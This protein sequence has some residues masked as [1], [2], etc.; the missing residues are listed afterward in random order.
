MSIGN[1]FRKMFFALLATTII[2]SGCKKEDENEWLSKDVLERVPEEILNKAKDLG[3]E[4]NGGKKPPNIEGSY[5]A[6]PVILVN[7]TNED[8]YIGGVFN[9]GTFIFSEQNYKELTVLSYIEEM[10]VGSDTGLGSFITGNGNKFSV[11]VIMPNM[12]SSGTVY[13]FVSGVIESGGIRNLNFILLNEALQGRLFKDGDELA[14]RTS[15]TKS[16]AK[17]ISGISSELWFKLREN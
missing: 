9:D 6:K 14:E 3:L 13:F 8:D 12:Y 4:I 1:L 5:Y 17:K 16:Y 10:G 11:F 7:S 15:T 2:F